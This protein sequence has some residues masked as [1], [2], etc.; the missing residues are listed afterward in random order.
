M[1]PTVFEPENPAREWPQTHALDRAAPGVIIDAVYVF[2]ILL[3]PD[4][5]YGR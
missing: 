1:L 3:L 2:W 5:G 4:D